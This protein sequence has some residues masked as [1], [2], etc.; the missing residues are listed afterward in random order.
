DSAQPLCP[1]LHGG[2]PPSIIRVDVEGFEGDERAAYRP[3]DAVT[4]QIFGDDFRIADQR[5]PQIDRGGCCRTRR[6]RRDWCHWDW[7]LILVVFDER[8]GVHVLLACTEIRKPQHSN[9]IRPLH[10]QFHAASPA[11]RSALSGSVLT[12]ISN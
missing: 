5:V 1:R 4:S 3:I 12:A 2:Q 10:G 7:A 8:G 6:R 11:S 9:V